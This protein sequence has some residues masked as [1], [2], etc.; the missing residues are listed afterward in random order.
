[1][2]NFYYAIT[3]N[4]DNE[5]VKRGLKKLGVLDISE[6]LVAFKTRSKFFMDYSSVK[7]EIDSDFIKKSKVFYSEEELK[8]AILGEISI[9]NPAY[10]SN[11]EQVLSHIS[12]FGNAAN[13]NWNDNCYSCSFFAERDCHGE[14]SLNS[15]L[16]KYEVFVVEDSIDDSKNG[17]YVFSKL[18]SELIFS[19]STYH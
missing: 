3:F 6:S 19:N 7:S 16:F 5:K 15:W 4:L 13:S 14:V 8:T 17:D 9:K 2:N 10:N 18:N 11:S 1:M 12:K